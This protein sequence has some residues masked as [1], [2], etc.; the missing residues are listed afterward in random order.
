MLLEIFRP[1][2]SYHVGPTMIY[3]IGTK[4]KTEDVD[5]ERKVNLT[6]QGKDKKLRDTCEC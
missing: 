5:L 1:W 3:Y 6:K 4:V 2:T